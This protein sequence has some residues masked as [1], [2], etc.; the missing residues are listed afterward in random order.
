[1]SGRLLAP[2]GVIGLLSTKNV[3]AMNHFAIAMFLLHGLRVAA[4]SSSFADE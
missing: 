3:M 1:L 2:G 4:V